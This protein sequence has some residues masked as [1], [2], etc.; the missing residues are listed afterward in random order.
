MGWF[1]P[2]PDNMCFIC[3]GTKVDI[4]S[5]NGNEKVDQKD[6]KAILKVQDIYLLPNK[7]QLTDIERKTSL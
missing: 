7:I 1:C 2:F 3:E 4:L 6:N 5:E